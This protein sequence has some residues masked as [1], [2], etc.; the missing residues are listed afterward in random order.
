[1][2]VTW[3]EWA[4]WAILSTSGLYILYCVGRILGLDQIGWTAQIISTWHWL[5][6]C[7]LSSTTPEKVPGRP[8]PFVARWCIHVREL[9]TSL[10]HTHTYTRQAASCSYCRETGIWMND[11]MDPPFPTVG[12]ATSIINPIFLQCNHATD[13]HTCGCHRPPNGNQRLSPEMGTKNTTYSL[14]PII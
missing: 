8:L 11:W 12:E 2:R 7:W 13:E 10:T 6:G 4:L 9:L 14:R 1:M 5:V 3:V